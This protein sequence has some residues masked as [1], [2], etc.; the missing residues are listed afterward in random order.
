[1][2]D[3]A[4]LDDKIPAHLKDVMNGIGRGNENVGNNV[5]RVRMQQIANLPK[6]RMPITN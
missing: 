6:I 1:M 3:L 2:N 4:I 5:I